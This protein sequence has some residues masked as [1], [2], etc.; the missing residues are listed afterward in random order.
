MTETSILLN[1]IVAFLTPML[2]AATDGDRAQAKE[3]AIQT[4]NAYAARN[5]VELLLV[6]QSIALGIAMLSSVS[7]SMA[8]NIPITLILRLRANAV[9]LHRAAERCRLALPRPDPDDVAPAPEIPLSDAELAR[10]QH[11][12]AGIAESRRHVADFRARFAQPK[13]APKQNPD[14]PPATMQAAMAALA[15]DSERRIAQADA[16]MKATGAAIPPK[17]SAGMSEDDY[18]RTAWSAAMT[19]VAQEVQ[20]EMTNLPPAERRLAAQRIDALN[21]TAN[22][23]TNPQHPPRA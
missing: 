5:P 9:S 6:G 12:V 22:N 20:A 1:L 2:G 19:D 21:A 3:A 18:F 8:E 15:A 14:T 11:I 7:L 13:Q 16:A 23:L 17:T 10:E 4:V